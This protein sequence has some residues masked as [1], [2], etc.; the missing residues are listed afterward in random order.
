MRERKVLVV[1]GSA[2]RVAFDDQHTSGQLLQV[3]ANRRVEARLAVIG[4]ALGR[5][6][7]GAGSNNTA[8]F[9]QTRTALLEPSRVK[10]AASCAPPARCRPG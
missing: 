5:G 2:L 1:A 10:H 3:R 4:Q 7:S 9:S 8:V 6:S